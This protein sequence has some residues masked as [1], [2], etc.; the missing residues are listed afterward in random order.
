MSLIPDARRVELSLLVFS[1]LIGA[2][3]FVLSCLAGGEPVAH[4]TRVMAVVGA[5][6][7]AA[8][9][10]DLLDDRRDHLLLPLVSVLCCL[11]VTILWRLGDPGTG[12]HVAAS[13]QVIW[14]L[15]GT[16]LMLMTYYGLDDVRSLGR[17]KYAAGILAV[18]LLGMTM[19][20][21]IEKNGAR[22]WLSLFNFVTFQPTELAKLLMAVFLAG[23]IA[24]RG[25]LLRRTSASRL[26]LPTVELRYAAPLLLMVFFC[27]AI[28][29][30]QRDLGAAALFLGLFIAMMYLATGRK[31][32][33]VVG[34]AV[35]IVGALV[36]AAVFPHVGDRISIWLNP[37]A[38]PTGKG[39]QPLQALFALAAGGVTGSGLGLG[40]AD[41]IPVAH[42][43]FIFAAVAEELGLLGSIAVLLLYTLISFRAYQIAWS[44]T[45]RFGALLAAALAT[46]FAL[47]S[48]I[49]IGG[50]LRLIPVTGMTLPFLSYGGTSIVCNFIALGLLMVVARDWMPAGRRPES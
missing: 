9:L 5:L 7:V 2:L 6:I 47:Q 49:V 15:L 17:L 10:M 21:G 19:L 48:I 4:A 29:V 31:G 30:L 3:A 23:Y 11:G 40:M 12:Q 20:W 38:D 50:V 43:D 13:K 37:W 42:S 27:L 33:G 44:A 39:Y 28:F 8:L 41:L 36:A 35:F 26:G 1:A 34:I 46:I 22:L 14:I 24:D 16:A 32:Y 25:E 45:D 18:V